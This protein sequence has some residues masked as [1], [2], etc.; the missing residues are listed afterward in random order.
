MNHPFALA[1]IVNRY[2]GDPYIEHDPRPLPATCTCYLCAVNVNAPP[3]LRPGLVG[4]RIP[5]I[6]WHNDNDTNHA[7]RAAAGRG[8]L[9]L[10]HGLPLHAPNGPIFDDAYRCKVCALDPHGIPRHQFKHMQPQTVAAHL[11]GADHHR[12][13]AAT[14]PRRG[15]YEL[16]HAN[17]PGRFPGEA[18]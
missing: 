10:A 12:R 16:A 7:R 3:A 17:H 6:Q 1:N 5:D 15:A 4:Q 13:I 11:V 8:Q 18:W 9:V 14:D 2:P